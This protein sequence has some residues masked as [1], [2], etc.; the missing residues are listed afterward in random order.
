MW[1][2]GPGPDKR[3]KVLSNV[4]GASTEAGPAGEGNTTAVGWTG[5]GD[6]LNCAVFLGTSAYGSAPR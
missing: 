5:E 4:C 2:A 1:N 6:S 3:Q